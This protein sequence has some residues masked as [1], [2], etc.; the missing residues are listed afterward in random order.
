ML[1]VATFIANF[2]SMISKQMPGVCR[3]SDGGLPIARVTNDIWI[4]NES[5]LSK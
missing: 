1:N 2:I 3:D 5:Q 4:T